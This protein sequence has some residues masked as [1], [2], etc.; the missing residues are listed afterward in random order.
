[1][2]AQKKKKIDPDY[3]QAIYG[4]NFYMGEKMEI[5]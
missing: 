1:M 5:F 3:L 2:R 4:G